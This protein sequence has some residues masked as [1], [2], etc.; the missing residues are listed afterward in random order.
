MDCTINNVINYSVDKMV[1]VVGLNLIEYR[2]PTSTV[3]I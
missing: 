2:M 1:F 3:S